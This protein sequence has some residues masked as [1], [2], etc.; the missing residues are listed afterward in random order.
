M[1]YSF[2]DEPFSVLQKVPVINQ[3]AD[4]IEDAHRQVLDTVYRVLRVSG[5]WVH[6]AARKVASQ[7]DTKK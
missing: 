4:P 1:H 5:K 7:A 6:S 3:I 2:A